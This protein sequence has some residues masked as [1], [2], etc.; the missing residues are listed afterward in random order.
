VISL[1]DAQLAIVATAARNLP[2]EKRAV[3]LERTAAQ[4]ELHRR[5]DDAAVAT[6][7]TRA[8]R[9]LVHEAVG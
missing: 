9:G 4:L 1:S 7:C 5:I 3:F 8:L 6:A 2:I